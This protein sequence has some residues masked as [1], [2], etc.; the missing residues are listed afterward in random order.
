MALKAC[1]KCLVS[2]G[3][4]F[5]WIFAPG[6]ALF[7][8]N[9]SPPPCFFPSFCLGKARI[10]DDFPPKVLVWWCFYPPELRRRWSPRIRSTQKVLLCPAAG[11]REETQLPVSICQCSQDGKL[12]K[13]TEESSGVQ[14]LTGMA[15]QTSDQILGSQSLQKNLLLKKQ[16]SL[17][18]VPHKL[19]AYRKYSIKENQTVCW[20][21]SW[22]FQVNKN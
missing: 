6:L 5:V 3:K 18:Y 1:Q 9:F 11:W 14:I 16:W 12:G 20:S 19:A 2:P 4:W 17:W 10:R 22:I 13:P 15:V 7:L 8:H 21:I